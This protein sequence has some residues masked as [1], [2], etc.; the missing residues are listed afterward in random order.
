MDDDEGGF[1]IS[2]LGNWVEDD[3]SFLFFGEPSLDSVNELIKHRSDLELLEEYHFSYDDWQGGGLE[4]LRVHPFVIIPPWNADVAIKKGEIKILLDPGVVFGTGLHPT[5][6]DCL[7]ALAYVRKRESFS[8]VVDLG[9]GTGILSLA[10]A[11]LGAKKVVAVDVNPLCVRTT[12][13]NIALNRLEHIV[14]VEENDAGR[15]VTQG[16]DL[17]MANIHYEAMQ[18]IMESACAGKI[19]WYI[20]SGLMRS[21]ARCMENRIKMNGLTIVKMWDHEMTWYTML[22]RG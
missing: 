13:R 21:Q 15:F 4:H 11:N 16:I 9:A 7:K 17:L 18:E 3:C 5:T 2:Y 8:H 6:R 22:L 14:R 12:R 19:R 20:L 10:A 1:G